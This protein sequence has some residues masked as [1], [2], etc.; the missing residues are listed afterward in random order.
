MKKDTYFPQMKNQTKEHQII[1]QTITANEIFAKTQI[2]QSFLNDYSFPLETKVVIPLLNSFILTKFAIKVDDKI[3]ISKILEKEKGKEKYTDEIASGNAAFLGKLSESGEK[4]EINIGNLLPGKIIELMTEYIQLIESED[5]SYCLNVIQSYPKMVLNYD[6][7]ENTS[8]VFQQYSFHGIK[9]NIYISAN[10]QLTRFILLNKR[11]D[12]TYDTK[13]FD[14]M[15]YAQVSFNSK[16][17]DN[18]IISE[19]IKN[20]KFKSLPYSPLKIIYRTE[21]I[22]KPLLF[23]QYNETND[24]TCYLLHYIFSEME[25][26]TPFSKIINN[27]ENPENREKLENYNVYDYIDTNEDTN[28]YD[29]YGNKYNISS[30][31]CYIFLLDQSGSMSGNPIKVLRQTIILFIKSL[32]FNSFFQIIGFGTNFI[33]YNDFPLLYNEKNIKE[34]IEE[35]SNIKA[36]LGGTNLFDPLKDIFNNKELYT[37]LDLPINLIIITDGKVMNAGSCADII[38]ENREIFKTHAIGD[39]Y[40]RALI[41]QCAYSGR[42]IKAFVKNEKYMYYPIFKILNSTSRN[43]LKDVNIDIKNKSNYFKDIKYDIIPYNNFYQ[44]D[45]IIKGF[46]CPGK[47]INIKKDDSLQFIINWKNNN[48]NNSLTKENNINII[49]NLD[50]GDELSKIIIGNIINNKKLN[51]NLTDKEI[52]GL[53]KKYGILS[54]LTCFF[55]SLENEEKIENQLLNISNIYVSDNTETNFSYPKTGKHGHAKVVRLNIEEDNLYNLLVNNQDEKIY[56][57]LGIDINSNDYKIVSDLILKQN[58]EKGY[59]EKIFFE[60]DKYKDLY[61]K[62]LNYYKNKEIKNEEYELICKTFLTIYYLEEKFKSYELI[63]KQ[64]VNKGKYYLSKNNIDYDMDINAI[65]SL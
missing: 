11:K 54:Y 19:T 12:F 55:G 3:I 56:Q 45:I 31:S 2:F 33:K 48:Y 8:H 28:Y 4:M 65:N 20:C 47:P 5:M 41:E 49:E 35:I 27:S 43:Y 30:P 18:T 9:C 34:I 21:N 40:D 50:N 42:G 32:P 51:K 1:Y 15:T 14:S 6:N 59:W 39:D 29:I 24:E 62:I 64:I 61:Q 63:W 10:N 58:L 7:N 52:I 25:I 44:D 57:R 26:Q 23:S 46:I 53:S 17:I 13:I 16:E 37:E 38:Y 22:N 36:T 60:Y